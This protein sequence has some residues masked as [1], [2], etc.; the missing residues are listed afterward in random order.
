MQAQST[1][2]IIKALEVMMSTSSVSRSLRTIKHYSLTPERI[3]EAILAAINAGLRLVSHGDD[4]VANGF[5]DDIARN[6]HDFGRLHRI[7]AS[8]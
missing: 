6:S 4:H 7:L 1:D 3:D 2:R 8:A 5:H